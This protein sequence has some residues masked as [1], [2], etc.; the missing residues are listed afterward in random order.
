[1]PHYGSATEKWQL[2]S[3]V[4][5]LSPPAYHATLSMTNVV[6]FGSSCP[7]VSQVESGTKSNSKGRY[8]FAVHANVVC[9]ESGH[10]LFT[11]VPK[12]MVVCCWSHHVRYELT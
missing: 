11:F 5:F 8:K 3:V 6:L 1:M 10:K 12:N 7:S 2:T 4:G 9:G